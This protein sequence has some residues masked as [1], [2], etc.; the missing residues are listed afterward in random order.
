MIILS[1]IKK[2][3][4]NLLVIGFFVLTS[5]MTQTW[6]YVCTDR[7]V[8]PT[9]THGSYKILKNEVFKKPPGVRIWTSLSRTSSILLVVFSQENTLENRFCDNCTLVRTFRC[10][11]LVLFLSGK[12]M[13][14]TTANFS[15]KCIHIATVFWDAERMAETTDV[16][17]EEVCPLFFIT[18]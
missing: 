2:N 10:D 14:T 16:I 6:R 5:L 3:S 11:H 8:Q 7:T 15:F 13:L 17:D 18:R 12:L 4:S 1:Y 9:N